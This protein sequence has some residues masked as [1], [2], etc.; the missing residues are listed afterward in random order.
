M[1][2]GRGW[3]VG[4]RNKEGIFRF[5]VKRQSL[6]KNTPIWNKWLGGPYLSFPTLT[7]NPFQIYP[8]S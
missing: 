5:L 2:S 1:K 7:I 8:N 4:R 6:I 3:G